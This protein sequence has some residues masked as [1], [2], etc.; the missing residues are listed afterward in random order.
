MLPVFQTFPSIGTPIVFIGVNTLVFNVFG[1]L[2]ETPLKGYVL[3][4]PAA[5]IKHGLLKVGDDI[6]A[7]IQK[8]EKPRE[9]LSESEIDKKAEVA[10]P[11]QTRTSFYEAGNGLLVAMTLTSEGGIE[12]TPAAKGRTSP[13]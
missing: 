12:L 8:L 2:V 4:I 7:D 6:E 13:E 9:I 3:T 1:S 5:Y 10:K 11:G